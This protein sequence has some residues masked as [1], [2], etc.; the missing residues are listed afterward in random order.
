MFRLIAAAT[1][2]LFSSLLPALSQDSIFKNRAEMQ[3]FVWEMM[4]TRNFEGLVVR[5]GGR[6][7]YT[8]EQLAGIQQQFARIYPREFTDAKQVMDL[9]MEN[10]FR[11]E[12]VAFWVGTSYAWL[13]I[14][15]HD[16]GEN[17]VVVNFRL[18]SAPNPIFELM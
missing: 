6:D 11:R 13:Y 2:F 15:S 10:G 16:T 3:G 12:V 4:K 1:L 7:E 5:L 8:K 18:N 17:Y 14:F 9:K